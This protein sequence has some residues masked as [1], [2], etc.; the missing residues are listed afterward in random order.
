MDRWSFYF[1]RIISTYNVGSKWGLGEAG[2]IEM[3]NMGHGQVGQ[4]VLRRNE[5]RAASSRLRQM[6]Y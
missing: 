6:C 3:I 2:C 4:G 1:L 5:S